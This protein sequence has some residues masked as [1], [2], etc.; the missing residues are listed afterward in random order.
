MATPQQPASPPAKARRC[1][2]IVE[3]NAL[4]MKLFVA[5][6]AAE[7]HEVVQAENGARALELAALKEPDLIIMDLQLP[8]MPGLDVAR[9]LKSN[10]LTRAIPVIATT[11]YVTPGDEVEIRASGCDAF[12]AKPIAIAEFFELIELLMPHPVVAAELV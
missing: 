5:M 3:D 9:A 7:G 4:N 1:V 10:E 12:M 11:A 6:I 2:L 8:D